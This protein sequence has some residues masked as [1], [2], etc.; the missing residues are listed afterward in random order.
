MGFPYVCAFH[1]GIVF[2]FFGDAIEKNIPLFS[3]ELLVRGVEG[4]PHQFPRFGTCLSVVGI[5]D[6]DDF[7]GTAAQR[8]FWE[9]DD[10]F[11]VEVELVSQ[12]FTLRTCTSRSVE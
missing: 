12:P 6:I 11:R 10:Q 3:R 7:S 5:V 2:Y 8:I 9:F 1:K 4:K